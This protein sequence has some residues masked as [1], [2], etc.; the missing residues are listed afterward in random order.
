[1]SGAMRAGDRLGRGAERA[2]RL[3]LKGSAETLGVMAVGN[4]TTLHEIEKKALPYLFD[5]FEN[6]DVT[7]QAQA[8]LA[9]WRIRRD[10]AEVLSKLIHC[11][12]AGDERTKL[13][14]YAAFLDVGDNATEAQSV[15]RKSLEDESPSVRYLSKELL[16]SLGKGKVKKE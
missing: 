10:P 11:W 4:G 2:I 16:D 6:S 9:I 12:E 7:G 5:T 1:M 8:A 3:A 13:I 15:I 14:V